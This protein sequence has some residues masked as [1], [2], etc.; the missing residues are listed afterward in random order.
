MKELIAADAY[1]A[2]VVHVDAHTRPAP[3]RT[4]GT[5]YAVFSTAILGDAE[6]EFQGL[7]TDMDISFTPQRIFADLVNPHP[8]DPVNAN[9]PLTEVEALFNSFVEALAVV[10]GNG[11]FVGAVTRN[12]VLKALLNRERELLIKTRELNLQIAEDHEKLTLWSARLAELH[13]ASRTLLSVLAHTQIEND[14]LQS[15]IEALCHLLQ[16]QYGAVSLIN[17]ADELTHFLHTGLSEAQIN[18]IRQLPQGRG[19]LGA[20]I[21]ESTAIRLENLA[22]DPRSVG[23]PPGH[24]PMTSLLAV[25][26]ANLGRVYGRIYLCDKLDG[27]PFLPE[28]ELLAMS[29]ATSLSLILDNARE[30]QEIKRGQ[31]HLYQLAHF[32]RLTGLPNRELAHDRIRQALANSH[33]HQTKLAVIFADLDNFKHV[34]DSLGHAV[35]DELLKA[36]AARLKQCIRESDTVARLGGDE[37]LILL[38]GITDVQHIIAVAQKIKD[39]LQPLFKIAGQEIFISI[40]IGIS[41]YP[42]DSIEIGELLRDADTAM[43]HAKNSGRNNFQF[44]TEQMNAIVQRQMR[45]ISVLSGALERGQFLLKYQPQIALRTG[46]MIGVEALLRWHSPELGDISPSEFIPVAEAAGLII[47]ISDWVLMEACLQ[48]KQWLDQGLTGL[49]V[50]VNLSA[51]QFQQPHLAEKVRQALAATGFPAEL[52]ELEITE[53]I[54][55]SDKNA[56][57][58][59]LDELK[60]L[61]TQI[62]IDDFGTGYSS[63]SYL[64]RLPIDRVKIDQ[65][66]VR[67]VVIDPND[68][69]IVTA[70]IAM[71]HGLNLEVIAEGVETQ[72]QLEFLLSKGCYYAQ[73]YHFSKPVGEQ[74]IPALWHS[75]FAVSRGE[76]C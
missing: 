60:A 5:V 2:N 65:S 13:L 15:G 9:T 12:S 75:G 1:A 49:R 57:I 11:H 71:T 76:D 58:T 19:L 36:V 46:K 38:P 54:M 59:L 20:V 56:I 8:L 43:Y 28:D 45:L 26:I 73:G 4:A 39:T 70:I 17:D 29:F 48:G 66:F 62:S 63:L 37:F 55:M 44:F 10:D 16:A 24:P 3:N 31:Q 69:A 22:A 35:G 61:G 72:A 47:A 42:D 74:T 7:V 18:G 21:N 32:D 50:A 53:S 25:P 41:I 67:D 52:L 30:I 14:I 68:A 33:R 34:N 27:T 51:V 6:G 40:S 23:F 64:K